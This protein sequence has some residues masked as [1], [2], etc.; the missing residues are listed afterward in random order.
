MTPSA[1]AADPDQPTQATFKALMTATVSNDYDGFVAVCDDRMKAAMTKAMMEG[2]SKQIAPLAK[3]G[4]D[5]DYL[6]ALNQRGYAVHLWR[7]RFKGGSD[8]ILATLSIK[9]GK[10]GGFY[11]H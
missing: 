2:V 10:A 9:D 5:A 7:L 11:L 6:G 1:R 8:D 3:A 4:Y